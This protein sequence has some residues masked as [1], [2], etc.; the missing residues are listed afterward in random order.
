MANTGECSA[1]SVVPAKLT[2]LQLF[3]AASIASN[4]CDDIK[5]AVL[6]IQEELEHLQALL[7]CATQFTLGAALVHVTIE[8]RNKMWIVRDAGCLLNKDGEIEV[9]PLLP[10]ERTDEFHARTQYPLEIAFKMAEAYIVKVQR[11]GHDECRT[12]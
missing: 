11:D 4:A 6:R 10:S 2:A 8:K 5:A 7:G 9:E 1:A 3:S 12:S